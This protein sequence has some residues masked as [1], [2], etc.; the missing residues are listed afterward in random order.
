MYPANARW[1]ALCSLLVCLQAGCEEEKDA[2]V[3]TQSLRVELVSPADPGSVGERLDDSDRDVSL[4]ISA[5]DENAEVDAT[6]E[7]DVDVYVHFLGG[8]TPDLGT[9]PLTAVHLEGGTSGEVAVSLPPVFGPTFLWIEHTRG[10][11][12]TFATGTSPTLWYRDPFLVDVSR[13]EDEMALDALESSPLEEK[14][15]NVTGSRYGARGRMVVTGVYAQ[16]YTLSDAECANADGDPPCVTS[17]YDHVFVF[18][19]NRPRGE[20]GEAIAVGDVVE[21]LTGAIG[22]FNGL[23]EVN[24]PQSFMSGEGG[25]D[26]VP[27]PFVLQ[28]E[29]LSDTINMERVEEALVA[30]DGI[31]ICPLDADFEQYA[32]WK[33]KLGGSC[34][35]GDVINVITRGQVNDFDPADYVGMVMP[36]VVGTLRPVNIGSFNVWILYPRSMADIELP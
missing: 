36:R 3:G 29:W 12:A 25:E 5:L 34:D 32:Q 8:L 10:G 26:L 19:F 6:F 4:V 28:P 16:G 23:T 14:Q 21:R 1:A 18:S 33:L 13:P 20:E 30:V 27:E 22:E 35:D 11:D 9:E 24:F 2:I 17:D 15:I 31:E 7:G